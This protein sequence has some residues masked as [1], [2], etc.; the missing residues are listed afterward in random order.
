MSH[1]SNINLIGNSTTAENI[2]NGIGVFACKNFGNNLQFKKLCGMGALSITTGGTSGD[3]IIIS[4]VTEFDFS[5]LT[6]SC[7]GL[8]SNGKTVCLG[9]ALTGDTTF[10]GA[11][12][13]HLKYGGDYSG[14]Y[15]ARSIIDAEYVTGITSNIISGT[16]GHLPKFNTSGDNI[17]NS[18]LT[19][20]TNVL[21]NDN[22]L[23]I[24]IPDGNRLYFSDSCVANNTGYLSIGSPSQVA[25]ITNAKI[26]PVGLAT[27]IDLSLYAKGTSSYALLYAPTIYIGG[28]GVDGIRYSNSSGRLILPHN[29]TL[30]GY[31]GTSLIKD[32]PPISILGGPGYSFGGGCGAGGSVLICGGDATGAISKSGGTIIFSAG[33]GIAGGANGKIQL[34][35]LPTCTTETC[36]IFIDA[37]GNLST[38]VGGGTITGGTNG[39]GV[40]GTNICLGGILLNNTVFIGSASNYHLQYADDYS[41]NY[42]CLSIPNAGWVTGQTGLETVTGVTNLGLGNGILYTSIS[43]K[44]LQFKTISG[45]TDIGIICND[46]YIG[47]NFTGI[48]G[49]GFLGTVTET[50]TEPSDL[51]D[52]QWVKPEP[53]V[54]GDFNYTFNN[55]LDSG[56]TAISVN[57]SLEDV[58]LR[59][60]G[61]DSSWVKES[62]SKPITS[63]H[64]WI[65]D[66]TNKICEIPVITEWVSSTSNLCY[67]GQKFAYPT[68]TIFQVDVGCCVTMPNEILIKNIDLKTVANTCIFSIPVG[69]CAM[70]KSA[71]LVMLNNADPDSFT[72]SIGNNSTTYDNMIANSVIDDVNLCE[73][74]DITPVLS[75]AVSV[76]S[77]SD[78]YFRVQSAISGATLSTNLLFD[79]YLF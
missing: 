62:Y 64:T 31:G 6:Y 38:G 30:I 5:G 61:D 69:M 79:G 22:D 32:S 42:S 15:S 11:D 45:G 54:S 16:S 66:A 18:S 51:A 75:C 50:T 65:G 37:S 71:K 73:V 56:S 20:V 13:C 77:G 27:D 35:A 60:N 17:E 67:A 70:V 8:S 1:R 12:A 48:T 34:C 41:A 68:Q 3:T 23:T 44:K 10:I 78:V 58:Y 21:C 29:A 63:G 9:G 4:G 72:V 49:G 52:N 76:A 2:G 33:A 40:D 28:V 7:N 53:T 39:L 14:G 26:C 43:D 36:N 74:Y 47:V 19:M 55:F 24:C 59:Y 46:N 57:L 25:T